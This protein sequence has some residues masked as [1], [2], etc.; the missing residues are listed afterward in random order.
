[1]PPNSLLSMR[2]IS[3]ELVVDDAPGFLVPQ[4]RHRDLAG[5]VRIA[6]RIGLVQI[7]KA[8]DACRACNPETPGSSSIRPALLLQA[9]DRV[10]DRDGAVELLERAIDQRAVRPR[11]AVRDIEVIAAGLR[12]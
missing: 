5:V 11:A 10:G 4:R 12:P 6:R 8:V 2:M 7:V 1:M 3:D 9:R